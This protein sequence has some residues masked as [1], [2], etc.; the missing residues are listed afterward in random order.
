M[1]DLRAAR[2]AAAKTG[3]GLQ[4]VMKEA[5]V[6]D[7]WTK[8]CPVILSKEISS[9]AI[10]LC[11][12]GTPLNKIYLGKVQRFSEDID[13]DIFFKNDVEREDKIDFIKTNIIQTL[14]GSYT[15]PK[16]ARRKNII[17]F[18]CYFQNE[19][20]NRDNIKL[21]FNIGESLTGSNEIASAKSEIL[22]LHVDKVPV[23]SFNTLIAKKLKAFHERTEGKDVYDIYRSLLSHDDVNKII[24][25]LKDTLAAA[26]IDYDEFCEQFPQKLSDTRLMKSL[27]RS[28]NSYI[29]RN[30]RI[31]FI[32]AAK[33]I[34]NKIVPHL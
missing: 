8:I 15:I 2:Q 22:P 12:G 5:R 26:H 17:M 11:K 33:D 1:V 3:I 29:P 9:S 16:E 14:N 28:A 31:D 23:Y 25:I 27:H 10:I 32:S 4:Y 18:M 13:M 34:S 21:E 6:F 30:L 20:E 7:I 24:P 19:Q